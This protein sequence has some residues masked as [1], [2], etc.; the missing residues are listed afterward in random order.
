MQAAKVMLFI[1]DLAV[2]A[3]VAGCGP[4]GGGAQNTTPEAAQAGEQGYAPPPELVAAAAQGGQ[5]ALSG[6]AEPGVSV[7][8]ATP[9]G[10]AVVTKAGADGRW[11]FV[12]PAATAPRLFGL[13]MSSG[14]RWTQAVGYLFVAPDGL[15][16]RLRAGGGSEVLSPAPP[17]LAATALDFDSKPAA[18]LSG[19]AAPSETVS[20][21]VD[22][23][24]RGQAQADE[25]GRFVLPLNEST[26]GVHDFELA[27]SSG[28]SRV[29]VDISAPGRLSGAPFRASRVATG[30]R[31]DWPAPGGGVQT[32]LVIDPPAGGR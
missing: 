29:T 6:R 19:R 32:T 17:S 4:D 9:M 13:S 10:S 14:G 30:W 24:E 2:L 31:I 5:V 3:A 8:L 22:G 23:V 12:V 18:T 28:Q 21:R 20:L 11:Q 15:A 1:A 27:A 25:R 7:R 26:G 16:A